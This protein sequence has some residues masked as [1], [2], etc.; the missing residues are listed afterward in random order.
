MIDDD[1]RDLVSAHARL[2]L[3]AGKSLFI[4]KVA[5]KDFLT[6]RDLA[7]LSTDEGTLSQ[8]TNVLVGKNGSGKSSLLKAIAFVLSE[9]Y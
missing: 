5:V 7:V 3:Q 1:V 4:K 6:Y 2:I 9:K 8:G